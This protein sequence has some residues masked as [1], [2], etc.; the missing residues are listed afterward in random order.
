MNTETQLRLQA[1]L[2]GELSE[3]ESREISAQ[4]KDDPQANALFNELQSTRTALRG[5]ELEMKLPETREFYWSKI[6]RE[7]ERSSRETAPRPAAQ[8]W[9]PAY[10]RVAGVFAAGCAVLMISFMAFNGQTRSYAMDEVEGAA[11][12]MGSI[13]F[14]SDKD[15]MTVVYLFNRE[16]I[17]MIN[18]K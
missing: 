7:V 17:S 5:N 12:D 6:Q 14:Q 9:K 2:D 1:Y 11:D 8:W 4:L 16:P 13:T 15:G 3:R 10:M 18:S